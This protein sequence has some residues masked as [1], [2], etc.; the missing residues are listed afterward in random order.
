[1]A[2]TFLSE[3]KQRPVKHHDILDFDAIRQQTA[4][5]VKDALLQRFPMENERYRLS[6]EDVDYETKDRFSLKEQKEAIL[7]GRPVARR[8]KGRWRLTDIETDK[9]IAKSGRLTLLN[10]PY[11]TRRGTYIR[12]GHEM[13]LA[14]IM[15]LRPGVYSRTKNNGINEA[16]VNIEQGTGSSFRIEI[17]PENGVFMLRKGGINAKLYPVLRS[18]GL[19]DDQLKEQWG[20][21]ILNA[22]IAGSRGTMVTRNLHSLIKQAKV[23]KMETTQPYELDPDE[24]KA[25]LESFGVMRVDPD[26]TESTLGRR[27]T[28]V[29]P[30]MLVLTSGKLLK[31]ARGE[32]PADRRDS[33]EFQKVYGPADLFSE[34]IV[35]DGGKVARN[36]LWKATNRGNL[37]FM[38][39]GSLNPHIN[40]VFTEA[41]LAQYIDGTSPMDAIDNATKVT[42]IGAGG[43]MDI[44]GTSDDMRLVQPSFKGYIDPIKAPESLRIGLDMFLAQGTRK[45][46]DNLLYSKFYNPRTG[47]HEW[48][49]SRKAAKANVATAEYINSKDPYI[50]I[51]KGDRGIQIV[52]RKDIDYFIDDPDKM[53]SLGSNMVPAKSGIKGMRLLMG[54]KYA[55]QGLPLVAREAPLVDN[56]DK[57]TMKSVSKHV[58]ALMGTATAKK[59]GVVK[60]VRKD[61]IDVEYMDGTKDSYELYENFPSNQKGY[62]RS[63]PKV[64]AGEPF[65]GGTVLATT[66][67]TDDEGTFAGGINLRTAYINW[68]GHNFEDAVVI[69]EGA[70]KKMTSENMYHNK[71]PVDKNLH[72]DKKKYLGMFPGKFSKE[73]FDKILDNGTI[74]QG[75]RVNY[76]DPLMLAGRE[77][78]PSPMTAGRRTFNDSVVTWDHDHPGIVSS[79]VVDTVEGKKDY[80][81]FTRAN[82]PMEVGDKL[83]ARFGNKGVVAAIIPDNQMPYDKNGKPYEVLQSLLGVVSRTN[84][85]QLVEVAL[86]KVAAKTGKPVSIPDFSDES[87]V[88]WT[89]KQL[90]DNN[91]TDTE[92]LID[93]QTG[94]KIP[95]IFTGVSYYYKLKHTAETKE[96]GRGTVGYT[97]EDLPAGGGKEGSKR[98]GGMEQS[99]IIGHQAM[100]VIKDAKLIRGQAN[101][102]FWRTFRRG[103]TPVLPNT[104]LIHDKF[105]EHLKGAG[106]NLR[107]TKD[108]MH[109]FGMTG[110]DVRKLTQGREVKT[111]DTFAKK[112]FKPIDG[113]LFGRDIFGRDGD[114][115][116][117]I[118]LDEP[119]PNPVMEDSLRRILQASPPM[120]V[121]KF[122][123]II[124][125]KEEL[126]G[127]TGGRAIEAALKDVDL[128]KEVKYTMSEID[129]STGARRDN[130]IKRY[131]ALESMRR[132]GL[133]PADFML[134]RIPVLPPKFRTITSHEG[135]TMVSDAN[136]MYKKMLEARNDYREAATNLP[137]EFQSE[138]RM[139][140]WNSYKALVGLSDPSDIKLQKK[141]VG[142]LLKWVFGKGSPK[143]GAFQ[144]K[145]IATSVDTVGRGTATPNPSLK[146]NQI[147][148]PEAQAWR[149][150]EPF[151][152]RKLILSGYPAT[153]AVKMVAD[154][155]DAAYLMLRKAVEERPVLINRAPTL[156]KFS[157]MGFWPVLTKGST[158]QVSPSIVTPFN[159][160]FDGDAVNFHVPISRSAVDE[161]QKKMMPDKNLIDARDFKAHHKP[162][163]EYLQG[164]YLATRRKPG[165]SV[166]SFRSAEEAKQALRRGEINVDDP[167]T[168]VEK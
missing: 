107:K 24:T 158:L 16:F 31:L 50:P 64:K 36:L 127:K 65:K 26:V 146:L 163:R 135:L 148:L 143:Y 19:S 109:I 168:I 75:T 132:Q 51:A 53:F 15:R 29:N 46:T 48:V 14:H 165:P 106:I 6:L 12:N 141:N 8:L 54:A 138:P 130:A 73:Q 62:L 43:V 103:E 161:I 121:K 13:T 94:N 42:R 131:R 125:G 23:T 91:L 27:F 100:D 113:G 85:A 17:N 52:P 4:D 101:D 80:V 166:K 89:E 122:N 57:S 144:R 153:E 95:K 25:L 129:R 124:A 77:N 81:V 167:I 157:I 97:T 45:G 83:S 67:Y 154:K 98:F 38:Q 47:K 114:Q 44:R 117:Y 79:I 145:V 105:Y 147:G 56:L 134:D 72:M 37:D 128:V 30:E 99:A 82:V 71:L 139:E 149:I 78:E 5:N 137:E 133:K 108:S 9:P 11:L 86:G 84:P 69:S 68:K 74:K 112:T 110:A 34:R 22:N 40:S 120:T 59:A 160:D 111:V 18:M 90:K 55:T 116:A 126:N 151:V 3:L 92:D 164:L 136:F 60:A 162:M 88:E 20:E 93:P 87:L 10:L 2:Q 66:N 119:L 21:D 123:D 140:L 76:G 159:L 32:V 61:R 102:E 28:N 104:P 41:K 156:H 7:N 63:I 155:H 58:G 70:A 152:V 115:W 118:Q 1:M 49:S 33:M 150:Y 35:K 142:G 96:S 39:S